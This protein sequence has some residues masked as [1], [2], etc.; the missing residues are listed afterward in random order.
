MSGFRK[1]L[2]VKLPMKTNQRPTGN[3]GVSFLEEE[4]CAD[5]TDEQH[6]AADPV[7]QLFLPPADAIIILTE[8]SHKV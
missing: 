6:H 8:I 3:C 1:Q 5:A 2:R 7:D 4:H